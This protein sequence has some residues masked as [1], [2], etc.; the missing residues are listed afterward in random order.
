MGTI[1]E[2]MYQIQYQTE[3]TKTLQ[4]MPKKLVRNIVKNIKLLADNPYAPNNNIKRLRGKSRY[5]LRVGDWRILYE[6]DDDLHIIEVIKIGTR[7]G[8][9][10]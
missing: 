3:A 4:R 10:K 5:R 6:I 9:Y 7:G 2:T 1:K 8:V